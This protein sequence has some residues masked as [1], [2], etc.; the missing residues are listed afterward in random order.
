MAA[1]PVSVPPVSPE[2][3][4]ELRDMQYVELLRQLADREELD[5]EAWIDADVTDAIGHAEEHGHAKVALRA[6]ADRLPSLFA[7]QER[8]ATLENALS[9][10]AHF[11]KQLRAQPIGA[12]RLDTQVLYAI[13]TGTQWEAELLLGDFREVLALFPEAA[14]ND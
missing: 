14:P 3:L 9:P 7:A 5:E 2:M 8:I 11:A 6:L 10:F 1:D 4:N 12:A 13:H